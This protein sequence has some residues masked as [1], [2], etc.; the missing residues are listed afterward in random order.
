VVGFGFGP[1]RAMNKSDIGQYKSRGLESGRKLFHFRTTPDALPPIGTEFNVMHFQ[2]GQ[3]IDIQG[4]TYVP[5]L[6]LSLYFSF[7]LFFLLLPFRTT[8]LI[9]YRFSKGKG[10]AGGMKKWGYS[11]LPASHGTSV[12][13]RSIGSTG[14][15]KVTI[16]FPLL[17]LFLFVH[18]SFLHP[19]L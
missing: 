18:S 4:V 7:V 2:L 15:R 10:F 12:S 1:T 19:F 17:F 14:N 9:P 5:F 3:L 13:H 11:G 16:K 8:H 6:A